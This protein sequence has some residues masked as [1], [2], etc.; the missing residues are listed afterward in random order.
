MFFKQSGFKW[1]PL[2]T[3]ENDA[4]I[5]YNFEFFY[6]DHNNIFFCLFYEIKTFIKYY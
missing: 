3:S 4:F 5:I 2:M 1:K 6:N